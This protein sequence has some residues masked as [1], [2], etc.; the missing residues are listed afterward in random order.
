MTMLSN[1]NTR[2][3]ANLVIEI[4]AHLS[5][6]LHRELPA[7]ARLKILWAHAEAVKDAAPKQQIQQAFLNL[8]GQCGLIGDLGYHGRADVRHVLGWAL[9]GRNP[10]EVPNSLPR[11]Q[12]DDPGFR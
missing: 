10:F 4:T 2:A 8:A 12:Y 6:K 3:E 5:R 11:R 9:L 1:D 7:A